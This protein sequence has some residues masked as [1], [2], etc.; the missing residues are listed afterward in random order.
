MLGVRFLQA[1]L[2]VPVHRMAQVSTRG[3]PIRFEEVSRVK[4]PC[5]KAPPEAWQ[6]YKQARK[7]HNLSQS[8]VGMMG[9]LR[10]EL[11]LAGGEKKIL[12]LAGDGSFCNRTCFRAP[13]D[14]TELISRTRKD[15]VLCLRAPEGG[16]RFYHQE[17]FTPDQVRQDE[18][19]EWK[20]TKVFYG[21]KRRKVRYKEVAGVYWQGGA[22]RCPVRLLVVAPLPIASAKAAGCIIANP[23]FC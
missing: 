23:P 13:R 6:E 5:R 14:R 2:L 8:F 19:R 3:L 7:Q 11:D 15:A 22:G 20:T 1:S 12:V 10:K 17:K 21:G 9:Q 4:K 16:R 18:Q